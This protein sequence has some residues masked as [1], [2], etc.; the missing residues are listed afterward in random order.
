M[1]QI[2]ASV[3]SIKIAV[4]S[5]VVDVLPV[6]RITALARRSAVLETSAWYSSVLL[7]H[8]LLGSVA[9]GELDMSALR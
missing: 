1:S 4:E 3:D 5:L 8:I 9:S 6:D 2:D 7:L